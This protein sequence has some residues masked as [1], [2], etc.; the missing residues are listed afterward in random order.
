MTDLQKIECRDLYLTRLL[1]NKTTFI[2]ITQKE[3]NHANT[4]QI[5]P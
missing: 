1:Q 3:N 5:S 2:S 4:Q